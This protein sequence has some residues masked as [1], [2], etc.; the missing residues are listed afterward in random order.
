MSV[1]QPVRYLLVVAAVVLALAVRLALNPFLGDREEFS[2]FYAVVAIAAWYGGY[3]LALVAVVLGYLLGD[4]FFVEPRF[5]LSLLTFDPEE[6]AGFCTFA[7]SSGVIILFSEAMRHARQKARDEAEFRRVTL[8]SIG[9]GVIVTDPQGR[10]TT[11]NAVAESLTG[12]CNQDA[13]GEPLG[14]V[15]HAVD[16]NTGLDAKDLVASV[17]REG[18]GVGP[19]NHALLVAKDGSQRPIDHTVAPIRDDQGR[20]RG[21]VLVFRD[22]SER[23]RAEEALREANQRKDEFLAMLGH[24]LRNPLGAIASGIYLLRTSKEHRAD[25]VINSIERQAAH[26]GRLLDDL[27]DVSRITRGKIELRR[28]FLSLQAVIESSLESVAGI[29]KEH[30]HRVTVS[31]PPEPLLVHGDRVRLEQILVNLLTNAA[32]Y[33]DDGGRISVTAAREGREA[34]VRVKDNGAGIPSDML[35]RVFELFIQVDSSLHRA[36]GGMGIGLTLVRRLVELHGGSVSVESEGL[37][38]GSQFTVRLP[39]VDLAP[40]AATAQAP[41]AAEPKPG[42]RVLLAEDNVD[43]A[44]MLAELLR[45]SGCEVQEVHDGPSAVEAARRLRP[46]AAI[47]DLGL[48]GLDGYEV[49]RRLRAEEGLKNMLLIALSGYGQAQAQTRSKETGFDHHLLKPADFN[50]LRTLLAARQPGA[51]P[52]PNPRTDPHNQAASGPNHATA[53]SCAVPSAGCQN[54]KTCRTVLI[55]DNHMV[56][57][58]TAEV[59]QQEGYTVEVAHDGRMGLEKIREVHPELVL[60]DLSLPGDLDGN[61]V[62]R[63]LRADPEF[64]QTCLIALTGYNEPEHQEAAIRSGFDAHLTKPLDLEALRGALAAW[65]GDGDKVTGGQPGGL[66]RPRPDNLTG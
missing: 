4:M 56:A 17:L 46:D 35:S 44:G 47:V 10:V 52:E 21:A 63:I 62:A 23:K 6:F 26:L 27:L 3:R 30:A 9:D 29:I 8:E 13:V 15:L 16:A 48:P 38:K 41:A 22:I 34:V 60:C 32:K 40:A 33:T 20:L 54:G 66:T 45:L 39:A 5:T 42:L 1:S 28:E 57:E 24:E 64:R 7:L 18:K 59:L 12:W 58:L 53:S 31:L 51:C 2:T 65:R 50:T 37:G 14:R 55:D 43:A 61:A 49:A 11:L 19:A 36:Q 25:W